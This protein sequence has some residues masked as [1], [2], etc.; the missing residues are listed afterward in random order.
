MLCSE[1][2]NKK[3]VYLNET[4][5][6]TQKEEV[7]QQYNIEEMPIIKTCTKEQ[8]DKG[9]CKTK[10]CNSDNDCL[11]NSC[12]LNSCVATD[13]VYLCN[14]VLNNNG[15]FFE[16]YK[17][18]NMKCSSDNE[19]SS[20]YCGGGYCSYITDDD[21]EASIEENNNSEIALRCMIIALCIL[22]FCN[23]SKKRSKLSDENSETSSNTNNTNNTTCNTI[24]N[25]V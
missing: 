13:V 12:Y 16:C 20:I 24:L 2:E 19:C 8:I 25:Q 3:C 5:W 11:S 9:D 21:Q 1:S 15:T 18:N 4:L 23:K 14:D 6:D 17:Y 22:Y 10:T 7:N